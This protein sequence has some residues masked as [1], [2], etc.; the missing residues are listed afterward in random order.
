MLV[1]DTKVHPVVRRQRLLLEVVAL[2]GELSVLAHRPQQHIGK[3]ALRERRRRA[4]L[5]SVVRQGH[6]PR[7]RALVQAL[8][9]RQHLGRQHAGHQPVATLFADLVQRVDRYGDGE[10]VF[11][12]TGLVQVARNAV[13]AAEPDRLRK[14]VRRDAGR[15]V[16]HQLVACELQQF[17]LALGFVVVPAL[18][19]RCAGHLGR[20]LLVVEGVD[21]LVLDEHVLASG[22]VFEFLDLPD[23][24]L[25]VRQERQLGFPVAPDQGLS[26]KDLARSRRVDAGELHLAVVV[27]HQ[28]IQRGTFER[29]HLADLLLPVR[30]EQLRLQQVAADALDPR[31]LDGREAAAEKPRGFHQLGGHQPAPGL[32]REVRARMAPE[33]DAARAE[34][35]VL[36]VGLEADVA[37][38]AGQQCEVDLL[39]V[40]GC[41]VQA[42]AV[43]GHHGQQLRMDVAPLA[44]APRRDELVAQALFLL[45]VRQLVAV[46]AF[47]VAVQAPPVLD[48][49]PQL[50]RAAELAAL[51]VERLVALVGQLRAVLRAVSHVLA[52]Q[53]RGD[54]QHFGERLSLAR[55]DD[56]AADAR[57]QRQARQLAPNRRQLVALVD[58]AELGQQRIAVDHRLVR[59]RLEK[60]K[61][62]DQTQP[63][64]LHA[65]DHTGQRGA[66]DFGVG[67]AWSGCE[68]GLVVEP[69]A[70]TAG[71]APAAPRAL[72][73]RRLADR[74]DLQLLDLVA[75]AVALD[76]RQAGVD[77][78]ADARHRQRGLGHIGCQHNARR[79]A[80]LEHAVLLGLRQPSEERQD[81]DVPLPGVVRQVLAQVVGGLAD[82]AL[83][84]Q[85]NE[86]VAGRRAR[87]QLVD[88]V[89]NR[90]IEVSLA[91]LLKRPP[92]LLDGKQPARDLDH[93]RRAVGI[94]E[95][96]GKP[97]GIDRRR[98]HDHLQV[99]PSRQHVLQVAE[100][101]VDVQ[102]ALVRLVDDQRVVGAQQRVALRFGQ[103][104][105]VG[106]QLDRGARR[107][108]V[109]KTDLEADDVAKRRLQLL[110]N[111]LGHARGGDAPR[112]GVADQLAGARSAAAERE[113]DLRQ[114]RG[115]ARAGFTT[116][117]HDRVRRDGGC[118]LVTPR[119]NRQR[120][121]KGDRGQRVRDGFGR[122]GARIIP[123]HVRSVQLL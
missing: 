19:A 95:V 30:F 23:Q 77:D 28:A 98:C 92:A 117:D 86:D 63:K 83:T 36:V 56:H 57:V 104:D 76:A 122:H 106:H 17:G 37:E 68:V 66:Q 53:R 32:L 25:V 123:R 70:G 38:Q 74:L 121:G 120:L 73:G 13:D 75:V 2:D 115:L 91:G 16:A 10:A 90:G 108:T 85:E 59:R 54:H 48:P 12:F 9:Q 6:E 99:R 113:R 84:G 22:L 14:G 89:G 3:H 110:G 96:P 50:Q 49:L 31:R 87:P 21:Q 35:P 103:Q 52:R 100:Q 112:L 93:W 101:E 27:D 78:V 118:D 62:F 46:A 15:L 60:R 42:P 58:R 51:V 61:V 116:D 64:R 41:R 4:E 80:G 81:V 40:G 109:L 102:R 88:R 20:Q 111:A 7:A 105:A 82:L 119:R 39:V 1:D 8:D 72:V 67:E 65:Q 45:A 97:V 29:N 5:V 94:L 44:H 24:L 47:L 114:L 107:Q 69:D 79:A 33:L 18:Q 34:V 55:L 26:D 71:H 43:F 11:G